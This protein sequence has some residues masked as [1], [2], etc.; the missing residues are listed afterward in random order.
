MSSMKTA[1]IMG[2]AKA[3]QD[4]GLLPD[5]PFQKVAQGAEIA[6][7]ANP[8]EVQAVGQFVQQQD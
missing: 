6:A 5:V 4:R 1:Y 2:A 3:F 7:N 8:A